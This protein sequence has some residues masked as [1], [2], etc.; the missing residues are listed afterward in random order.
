MNK[1]TQQW[2]KGFH[3]VEHTEWIKV[4]SRKLNQILV[5]LSD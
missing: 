3:T 5:I 2:G 4:V 1:H